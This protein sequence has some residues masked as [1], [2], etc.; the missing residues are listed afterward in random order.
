MF[1]RL[2]F[3]IVLLIGKYRYRKF[4][5][6]LLNRTCFISLGNLIQF[7]PCFRFAICYVI[8]DPGSGQAHNIVAAINVGPTYHAR[9]ASP[10][11][12]LW[13]FLPRGSGFY[14]TPFMYRSY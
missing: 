6:F 13:H 10:V 11:S 12:F 5:T 8:V 4:E 9:M 14:N 2:I 1:G 7:Q 3:L